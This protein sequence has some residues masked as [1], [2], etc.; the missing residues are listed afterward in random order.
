MITRREMFH[1][2]VSGAGA[3]LGAGLFP[4]HAVGADVPV[5]QTPGSPKRV[6]FFMQNHGFDPL[7]CIPKDL[8]KESCALDGLTLEKPMEALEPY[9]DRMHIITGLHGRHTNPGHSAYFGALGAYRGGTGVPPSA[10]TIDYVLSQ[11]LPPTIMPPLCIGMESLDSMRARPT[12]ATLSASGPNQPIFM[13]CDPTMLYQLLFGSIAEGAIR[14]HYEAR[15]NMML[16][17]ERAAGLKGKGLPVS[18][19]DRYGKYVSGF[20]EL[21]GLTEKLSGI[22]DRLKQFAPKL[23]ERYTNP[24]FETD[25]HDALLDIGIAALQANLTNVLTVASG[26]G[27][28]F[29]SWK[30]L[31]INE[32]GHGLGHIDQPGNEI[33]TK[34]RQ[35]NCGMLVRLMKALEATP[36][37][38]G[39]MMDNTLIVYSSNNAEKQH[40]EGATWPFVLLGNAGGRFKTGQYTNIK[41]RPINDLYAT[42][43]H[44]VGAPVDRFN[45]DKNMANLHHSKVGPIEE[46]LA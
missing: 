45:M 29:G 30:G 8:N 37:G 10:A 33:W 15:A 4:G 12:L 42:F 34:I 36:E 24:K 31:G 35:Y 27:E 14:Q 40:S 41:E 21:N 23:D 28:Y 11:S 20:R 39:T 7:T 2:A 3:L 1:G 46:L 5:I 32:T 44:G 22:S 43:L 9:K 13:H 25:W 26:C 6:I 38:S 16:E 19:G 18:D 17:V